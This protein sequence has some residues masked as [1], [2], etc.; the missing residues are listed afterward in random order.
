MTMNTMFVFPFIIIFFGRD[1]I[2]LGIYF[3]IKVSPDEEDE[4]DDPDDPDEVDQG[5]RLKSNS[6]VHLFIWPPM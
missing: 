6:N 4:E 5:N 2:F 3:G 1:E